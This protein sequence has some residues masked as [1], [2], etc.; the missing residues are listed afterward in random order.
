MREQAFQKFLDRTKE[1]SMTEDEI[2]LLQ[3]KEE[4][5]MHKKK[6]PVYDRF[7]NPIVLKK[8]ELKSKEIRLSD[9]NLRNW[10]RTH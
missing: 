1:P 3:Y 4:A 5:A 10:L 9:S 8:E 6:Y 7:G 2:K